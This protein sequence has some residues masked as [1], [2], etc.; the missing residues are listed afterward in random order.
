MS[1]FIEYNLSDS[2][3]KSLKLMGYVSPTE[4]QKRTIPV[5]LRKQDLIIKSE[6]GSGK[7]AAFAIPIIENVE[8]DENTPQVLVLTPTRELAQQV[9]EEM[10]NIGRLKRMKVVTVFG[11]SPIHHQIR[12]LKEKTHI[13]VGT[14][15]RVYDH[16]ERGTLNLSRIKYI[17]LDEADEMLNMGFVD[18]INQILDNAP[19]DIVMTLLSATLPKDVSEICDTYMKH[20]KIVDLENI[21]T[22]D[23]IE[24]I[25]YDVR[26]KDKAKLLLDV[27]KI[28]NPDSCIVFCNTRLE[29]DAVFDLLSKNGYPVKKLHGGMEQDLR[30]NVMINFRKGHFRYLVAT[31][32]A[33]RGIDIENISLVINY[34]L[35][36]E[37]EIYVHRIG[38]T[39][40]K[41]NFGKAISFVSEDEYLLGN[42]ERLTGVE[43]RSVCAPKE[44][45]V[46][47]L[48]GMFEEKINTRSVIIHE[49]HPALHKGILKLHINAGKKTKMRAGDIVGTL[50]NIEGMTKDDI[51]NI[52]IQDVS[53]YVE[54][55]NNKGDMVLK[56]LQNKP[57]KGRLRKVSRVN[58]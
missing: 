7:T 25:R 52:S 15:G 53:T 6:T 27:T 39:G 34:D 38:R 17:V 50:C 40:R 26:K 35:P 19:K 5:I 12:N 11:K 4:V 8:W 29:V 55:L 42:I 32:V 36:E 3:L 58:Q 47:M 24:E 46:E 56:V 37:A 1:A 30:T 23:R 54:I 14:P 31:D 9:G 41:E 45:E 49:K 51:G 18:Q 48:I 43:L 13:V 20:P 28:E 33:A 57:I 2:I 10:F 16:I 22:T 44:D 21:T